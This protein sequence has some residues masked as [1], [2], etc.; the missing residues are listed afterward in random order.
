[1]LIF[2]SERFAPITSSV[3]FL[4]PGLDEA[5]RRWNLRA[6]FGTYAVAAWSSCPYSRRRW[7]QILRMR[8]WCGGRCCAFLETALASE[9]IVAEGI[10]M[11]VAENFGT[12]HTDDLWHIPA[13]CCRRRCGPR[14]GS[15]DASAG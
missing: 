3:E 8:I 10:V 15:L 2:L 12:D 1:M 7:N 4:R 13:H 11:M 14:G 6:D 9:E 5:S